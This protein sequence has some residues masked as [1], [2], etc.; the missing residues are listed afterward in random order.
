MPAAS[1]TFD[2]RRSIGHG[3]LGAA[4][5]VGRLTFFM[6]DAIRGLSEVRIWWPRMMAEAWNIGAGSLFIVL[7]ISAFAGAVTALQTGYQFTGSIPYYVVG[8]LV[9]SSIIL[10]LGP[11][12][13]ALILAGRIGARYAAELGT[14]RVT[15]QIDALESLG[16]S[17]ASHLVLPRVIAGFIMIPAL[18]IFANLSGIAAGWISV[19]A[20]LPVTDADFIYGAQYYYRPFDAYYSI[21]K[22][23]FFAG[24]I[25]I[26]SCYMGFNTKQGAEGVGKATTTA[27]VASSVLILVLDTVLTRLL[28]NQ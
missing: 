13:T 17:P 6:G 5:Q 27:V 10:E 3:T 14:M 11:V 25:T 7:L 23:F 24:A 1:Q 4:A 2:V 8:T 19:K 9:V 21:I 28:L 16:R 18:T 20:V 15:E 26:I 22:A 12:L